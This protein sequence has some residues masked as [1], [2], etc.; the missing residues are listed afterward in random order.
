MSILFTA[1]TTQQIDTVIAQGID[2]NAQ[3]YA[4]ETF[5]HKLVKTSSTLLDHFLTKLPN[6]NIRNRMGRTAIFYANDED[7]VEKLILQGATFNRDCHGKICVECNKHCESFSKNRVKL[8]DG[9]KIKL[10][11]TVKTNI[12]GL[13]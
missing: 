4:G 8:G 13:F 3:D 1:K 10:N 7:T 11:K 2:I 12:T 9:K 5:L 6:V